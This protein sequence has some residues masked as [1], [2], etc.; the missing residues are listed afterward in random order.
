MPGWM[1]RRGTEKFSGF[2]PQQQGKYHLGRR[3][4]TEKCRKS[5]ELKA[6]RAVCLFNLYNAYVLGQKYNIHKAAL[7]FSAAATVFPARLLSFFTLEPGQS[8]DCPRPCPWPPKGRQGLSV[9]SSCWSLLAPSLLKGTFQAWG[10]EGGQ[11]GLF[12]CVHLRRA[13]WR[14]GTHVTQ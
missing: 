2:W 6:K 3:V 11:G 8:H 7:G 10:W 12:V 9:H 14:E 13:V 4:E 5:F 1:E